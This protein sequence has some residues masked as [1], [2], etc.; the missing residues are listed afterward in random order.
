MKKSILIFI[1][2]LVS[3]NLFAQSDKE[4]AKTQKEA[5]K[6]MEEANNP[7]AS[8][9]SF[10]VQ[11][12]YF[13]KLTDTDEV[14]NTAWLRFISPIG[15]KIIFRASVP[16]PTKYLGNDTTYQ[17][18]IG[19]INIFAAY[20]LSKPKATST[21]GIGPLVVAPTITENLG[22]KKWQ[23][24]GAFVYFNAKSSTLQWGG[25]ITYQHSVG[26]SSDD[27]KASVA[28]V[29]PFYFFQLGKGTYLR[30]APIWVFDLEN[31]G[32]NIPFGIGLGKVV[33]VDKIVFN[34]F[35]ETQFAIYNKGGGQPI[36]TLFGGIN[37]QFKTN[38]KDKKQ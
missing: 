26:G 6:E 21:V 13:A 20:L 14:G 9:V 5:Q 19:N 10:N 15:K 16:L 36:F 4:E 18:G 31:N 38:K 37:M 29:Q 30:G 34:I 24:G 8:F 32:I 35:L 11:D 28:A 7:L 22:S 23:L 27:P 25:L 12:Y 3:F 2:I 33:P 17:S 1:S